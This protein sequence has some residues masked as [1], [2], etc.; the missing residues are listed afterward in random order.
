M[1]RT[2]L[3]SFSAFAV[4]SFATNTLAQAGHY[5]PPKGYNPNPPVVRDHRTVVRDHRGDPPRLRPTK[6]FGRHCGG[7]SGDPAVRDHRP[8]PDREMCG[9]HP[10]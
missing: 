5:G 1:Y 2:V 3:I 6:C 9:A 4:M 10:C 7:K 8:G